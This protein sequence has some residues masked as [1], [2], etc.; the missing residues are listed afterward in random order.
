VGWGVEQVHVGSPC[1]LPSAM[2]LAQIPIVQKITGPERSTQKTV[3]II[4]ENPKKVSRTEQDML[5]KGSGITKKKNSF[6]SSYG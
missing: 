2:F 6:T 3:E 5:L 1:H 4:I